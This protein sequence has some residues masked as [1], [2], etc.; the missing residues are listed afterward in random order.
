MSARVWSWFI[1]AL[2]GAW[3]ILQSSMTGPD[4][5]SWAPGRLMGVAVFVIA[6]CLVVRASATMFAKAMTPADWGVFFGGVST[7]EAAVCA[8]SV[9]LVLGMAPTDPGGKWWGKDN[10]PPPPPT[11][12]A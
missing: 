7:F 10:S 9:G 2:T 1:A 4:G 6:Q 12:L 5:V 3:S 11:P 8:T